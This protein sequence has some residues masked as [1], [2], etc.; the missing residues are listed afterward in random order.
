MNFKV[1]KLVNLRHKDIT[2]NELIAVL[3]SYEIKIR[4]SLPFYFDD[5]F[6]TPRVPR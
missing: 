4:V 2:T 6:E 5:S 1:I 3:R